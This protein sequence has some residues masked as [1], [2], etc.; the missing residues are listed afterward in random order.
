MRKWLNHP[1]MI[2]VGGAFIAAIVAEM[3]PLRLF[4]GHFIPWAQTLLAFLSTPIRIPQWILVS[5]P[6]AGV[7]LVLVVQYIAKCLRNKRAKLI[8]AGLCWERITDGE[9]E[10]RP[11]CNE[12]ELPLQP[13]TIAEQRK[14]RNDVP[15]L[16]TPQYENMLQCPSCNH[17]IPLQ[18]PWNEVLRE[19]NLFFTTALPS[20]SLLTTRMRRKDRGYRKWTG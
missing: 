6:V 19:A 3:A 8:F 2:A 13:L 11:I 1:W 4:S 17:S 5:G 7:A 20:R 14:D 15:F 18:R 12:C 10:F 16:F 9:H